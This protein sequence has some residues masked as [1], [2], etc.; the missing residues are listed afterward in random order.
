MTNLK[1]DFN[2]NQVNSWSVVNDGVMGGSSSIN[3]QEI[4]EG[5]KFYGTV[6]L[7]TMGAL[8]LLEVQVILI[9]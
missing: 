9:N 4:P 6:S 1:I 3:I 2:G 7:K 8:L 5:F